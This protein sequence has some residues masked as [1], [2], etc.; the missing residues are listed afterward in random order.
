MQT[1]EHEVVV[2]VWRFVGTRVGHASLKLKSPTLENVAA[3]GKN[4]CYVS[5]W[6]KADP[7][8]EERRFGWKTG[9]A[10]RTYH[11]DR[12]SELK[13]KTRQ[14]LAQ[15]KFEARG[16]QKYAKPIY[17]P[18]S[19]RLENSKSN[20]DGWGQSADEKVRLPGLGNADVV[21][22]L[23]IG[24]MVRWWHLFNN[25]GDDR[26]SI[27][28]LNC[29]RVTAM[30]L[31]AGGAGRICKPPS[32]ALNIWTPNTILTWTQ[33]L[34]RVLTAR[35]EAVRSINVRSL[36]SQ[37]Q[38]TIN[39]LDPKVWQ[40]QTKLGGLSIRRGQVVKID[41]FLDQLARLGQPQT[42]EALEKALDLLDAVLG[43]VHSHIIEKGDVSKNR[44]AVS[45]LGSQ[46]L[47]TYRTHSRTLAEKIRTRA[48]KLKGGGKFALLDLAN[49]LDIEGAKLGQE[50]WGL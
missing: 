43:Q 13:P 31:L 17:L 27:T 45:L 37:E 39:L 22:G 4:H 50:S 24:A 34:E 14:A 1:Y 28:K 20:P 49:P 8:G 16:K 12:K 29:S 6:P 32:R 19:E 46:A 44:E 42:E 21:F 10:N 47:R 3:G 5:W 9:V 41:A 11:E 15:G 40:T 2:Y 26:F 30:C 25:S 33:K 35:N 7:E 38:R 48:D 36:P 23:D 18:E